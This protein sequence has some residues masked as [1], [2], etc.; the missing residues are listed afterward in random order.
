MEKKASKLKS[1]Q[2]L[3]VKGKLENSFNILNFVS[4]DYLEKVATSCG[5]IIGKNSQN[6]NEVI[7]AMQA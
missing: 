3:E 7:S 1:I 6:A 4:T 5:V 2:N